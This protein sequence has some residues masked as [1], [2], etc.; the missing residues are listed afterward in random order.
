MAIMATFEKALTSL[1]KTFGHKSY[2]LKSKASVF[3]F[4]ICIAAIS[5]IKFS[6]S[7]WMMSM[8]GNNINPEN[9]A[10]MQNM[11][12]NLYNSPSYFIMFAT[13]IYLTLIFISVAIRR[14][15]DLGYPVKLMY[16]YASLSLFNAL[17]DYLYRLH[18][19]PQNPF[20]YQITLVTS[21]SALVLLVVCSFRG[22]SKLETASIE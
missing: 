19:V 18:F 2:D 12:N 22:D 6:L 8:I 3:D 5:I 14:F 7:Y 10:D 15:N 9:F 4:W 20:S 1:S 11:L 17:S 21:L 13:S 16:I